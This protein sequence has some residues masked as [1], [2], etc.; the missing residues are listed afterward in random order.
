MFLNRQITESKADFALLITAF[1]W[2]AALL[3]IV[4]SLKTNDVFTILFWRFFISALI[5]GLIAYKF[6][7]FFDKQAIKYGSILGLTLFLGTSF[8][9]SALKYTYSSSVSF[10]VSLYILFIPF[11]SFMLFKKKVGIYSYVGMFFGVLGLFLLK[12]NL[13]FGFG[14]GE[15]LS[16]C[17][18]VSL[19]F[20]IV[21]MGYFTKKSE[22]FTFLASQFLVI[23]I[24][25]FLFSYAF[26]GGVVPT[27]DYAFYKAMFITIFFSTVI[28][29]GIEGLMLRYTTPVKAAIIFI[30]KS[31]TA[32]FLGYFFGGEDLN[33][34][35]ILGACIIIIGILIS[36][37]GPYLNK[38]SSKI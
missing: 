3:P 5:M 4:A 23:S 26:R 16:I 12:R 38:K 1:I 9:T 8:Q 11:M 33:R 19:A 29:F 37:V 20:H 21:F 18:A 14:K 22:L 36:E 2:G 27:L 10:I 15:I 30:F 28:G 31:V 7:K 13:E 24:C 6:D 25:C 35:Q 34:I 32:G 17:S